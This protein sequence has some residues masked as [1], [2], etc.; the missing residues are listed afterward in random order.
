MPFE[1][2]LGNP[3]HLKWWRDV[4]AFLKKTASVT[5]DVLKVAGPILA[6]L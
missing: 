6:A 3:E 2:V 5:G 4:V 1:Q